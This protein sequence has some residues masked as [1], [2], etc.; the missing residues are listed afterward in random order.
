MYD[1]TKEKK[2]DGGWVYY[3]GRGFF[4]KREREFF[5]NFSSIFS[6]FLGKKR[7][8]E[9]NLGHHHIASYLFSKFGYFVL[10]LVSNPIFVLLF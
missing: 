1:I 7:K 8:K 5:Q 3:K 4:K 2:G 10:F 6:L 9:K